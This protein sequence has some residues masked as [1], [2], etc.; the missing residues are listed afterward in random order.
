METTV[1]VSFVQFVRINL[2][3]KVG[4]EIKYQVSHSVGYFYG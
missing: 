4:K 2:C 3:N 1:K